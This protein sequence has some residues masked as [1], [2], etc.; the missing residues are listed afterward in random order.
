MLYDSE[1]ISAPA[2]L[3]QSEA[4]THASR[5]NP[6]ERGRALFFEHEQL[7]LV[8]KHYHRGGL[9]GRFVRDTYAYP[10]RGCTRMEAEF[11]LLARLREL[12]LPVPVPIAARCMQTSLL[13]Y[14]GD[15]VSRC[16]SATGSLYTQLCHRVLT[17]EQWEQIG[18]TIAQFHHHD[19]Y[20]ADLNA[21]NILLDQDGSV[22]L[23]DFDKGC[24][25]NGS[26]RWKAA[27]LERLQRSLHKLQGSTRG[28]LHFSDADWQ[29]LLNGYQ[30]PSSGKFSGVQAAPGHQVCSGSL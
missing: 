23:I 21:T 29:A 16:I 27:N 25:R 19:I 10:L 15:L 28:G 12:A 24:I 20:H 9:M 3:F 26:S 18:R 8:L 4:Y 1:Q 11:R 14:R 7:P 6:V 13:T 5:G 2:A 30:E 17:R 22:Y